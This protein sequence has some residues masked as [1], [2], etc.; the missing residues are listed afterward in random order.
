[1]AFPTIANRTK[2][3]EVGRRNAR[4]GPVPELISC[5]GS[6]EWGEDRRDH[7][8]VFTELWNS[9]FDGSLGL[10]AY[11]EHPT[12]VAQCKHQAPGYSWVS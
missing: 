5:C 6:P 10:R 12:R 8:E 7:C 4:E 3:L 2:D 1:M 9:T 11:C